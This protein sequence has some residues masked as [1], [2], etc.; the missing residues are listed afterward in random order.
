VANDVQQTDFN[1]LTGETTPAPSATPGATP[2]PTPMAQPVRYFD[3]QGDEV[4]ATSTGSPSGPYLYEV[5]TVVTPA[6]VLPTSA[7]DA[8]LATVLIQI[9]KNP[10]NKTNIVTNS[11]T[12]AWNDPSFSIL[13]YTDFVSRN[14]GLATPSP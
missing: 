5:N 3:D 14:Q 4:A 13:S 10:N 11:T 7:A 12:K 2:S 1:V 6:T 9:I 8:N